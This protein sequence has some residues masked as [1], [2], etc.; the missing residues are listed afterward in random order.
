M[1]T[2]TQTATATPPSLATLG[3]TTL[4]AL[5]VAAVILVTAVLPAEYAIDPLGTGRWLGLT[6]IAAPTAAPVA[7]T[8][9]AGAALKPAQAG[10][11]AIYP[12]SYSYDVYEVTLEPFEYVEYKYQLEQDAAMVFSWTASA[13]VTQDF[14]GERAA[15]AA[16]EATEE[17]YDK[18]DRQGADGTFT[19]PFA[20]IHGWYW[21]NPNADP[22]T[23]RL[24]TSGYYSGAFEIRSDRTRTARTLRGPDTWT[25]V[26]NPA[27]GQ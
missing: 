11:V 17:S 21:E 15:A 2:D 3:R 24:T 9:R 25:P 6:E 4:V 20:G 5:A 18:V 23:V 1:T 8:R 7:S 26:A 16:G 12:G 14:H 27:A 13:P 22:V 10:R 19:A